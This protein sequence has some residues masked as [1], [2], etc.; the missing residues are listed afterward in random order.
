MS[1]EY[2]DGAEEVMPEQSMNKDELL[3]LGRKWLDKIAASEKREAKWIESAEKAEA[4][5]LADDDATTDALPSFNILHSNV[6]TI[7]PSIFNSSPSPDIRPRHNNATDP[8]LKDVANLLEMAIKTQVDDSA[9][10]AEV[11]GSAQDA[12]MAGRGIVRI[13][14]EADEEPAQMEIVDQIVI[15]PVTGEQMLEQVEVEVSPARMVNER[16]LY[17]TVSW[18][19][20]REG[21][22]KRWKDVPWIAMRHEITQTER[23]RLEQDEITEAMYDEDE[24]KVDED[25]D[26]TVWE[27]WCKETGKVYF[28][29]D[30]SGEVVSIS[31]DPLGL[32]QFFPVASPVQPIT[33]TG[34]RIPVTPY[35][36]Y[37]KLAVELDV[38]TKRI[39]AIM[40]GLKVRGII[41]ADAEAVELM[42]D[43]GDNELVP[44]ANIE[45]LAAAGGLDKAIMWWP[46]EQ[47][48]RVLQQ[49]YV[50][51][52]QTKAAIYEITG[53]SDIIRG[54]GAA[55]ETATA[56]QIKTEWGALRVKKMQR[57]IERQVRELF[58]ITSEII[59]KHFSIETLAK[60]TGE[61][62]TP[63][64]Q[65]LLQKPMDHYRIDVE[66]D[67]TVRA[68]MTKS[69]GEMSAFLQ[70][71]AQFFST[72]QPVVA[73][74]PA[75]AAPLAKMYASFARQFNLGKAGEDAIDQFAQMAEE[76][77][78]QA[79]Q[80]GPSPEEQAMQAQLQMEQ[81][82][83]QMDQKKME[84][85]FMNMQAK[86]MLEMEKLKLD[87]EKMGLERDKAAAELGLKQQ[88]VEIKGAT[89][90][91]DAAAK[92]AEIELEIDQERAV[93][94][95][96]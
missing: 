77:A 49:L 61:E 42:S 11:E 62:I 58:L 30:V 67:S 34:K 57:M 85:E 5:Y 13:R 15:D 56:Q 1:D 38:A 48:V 51:R 36:I 92:A 54:Q 70:G 33:G 19:D 3:R 60:I 72:M 90:E 43:V 68:D 25:K 75:A 79:G 53:I 65:Q 78:Q 46:I 96:D 27:I 16:V 10:D 23:E 93:R 37:E 20:Y 2:M 21:P 91:V 71:T 88:E 8:G 24:N 18:R 73:S 39:N 64:A 83:L 12:F 22:A 9:M 28:V 82:K 44:I 63:E 14:F 86:V 35:A 17:E 31:D 89:A 69:R 59:S 84:A 94:I 52:E 81:Q 95:G 74:A 66:S 80:E 26:C 4:A 55:S 40:K 7:V 76:Q 41:A 50:Q 87:T 32:S 29:V 47:S 45:N 6:E